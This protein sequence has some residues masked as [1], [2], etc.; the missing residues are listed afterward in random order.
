MCS[1]SPSLLGCDQDWDGTLAAHTSGEIP[2][3]TPGGVHRKV[4]SVLARVTMLEGFVGGG[5]GGWGGWGWMGMMGV[6]RWSSSV[7]NDELQLHF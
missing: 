3:Y 1:T 7:H 6:C 5:G 4:S 2:S